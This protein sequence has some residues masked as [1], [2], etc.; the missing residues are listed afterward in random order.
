MR[1]AISIFLCL[2][3]VLGIS[4]GCSST[5]AQD[6]NK[7]GT[8]SQPGKDNSVSSAG[9]EKTQ[10]TGWTPPSDMMFLAGAAAGGGMDTLVRNAAAVLNS[11]GI[12]EQP[13]KCDNITGGAGL[14]LISEFSTSRAGMQN[15]LLSG[16]GALSPN[17]AAGQNGDYLHQKD[18]TPICRLIL[19]T[20]CM[21]CAADN[22]EINTL[23][24]FIAKVKEDPTSITFG[25][26]IPPGEDYLSMVLILD[27]IGVDWHDV[28]YVYYNGGGEALPALL[29]HNIDVSFS[30]TSEW[31]AAI[32]AGQVTC[33]ATAAPEERV[34][35]VFADS[36]TFREGGVDFVWQN[37][38]GL[39]GPSNIPE[40]EVK[41]WQEA[42]AKMVETDEWKE[43]CERLNYENGYMAEGFRDFLYEY[44]EKCHQALVLAD[45]IEE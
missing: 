26:T 27:A 12:V 33:I 39:I 4:S 44:E 45:I 14:V 15:Q 24:K 42:C 8:Q 37:W 16:S 28:N 41:Y 23:D 5:P 38:R 25:G 1:K 32:E 10:G 30:G 43:V 6:E 13:I 7:Q 40:E 17:E 19:E 34:G 31:S 36:P 29:G 3:L 22:E 18:L 11:T 35:G 9:A 21:V 20:M 2:A